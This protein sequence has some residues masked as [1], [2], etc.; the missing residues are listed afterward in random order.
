M[1][2][3]DPK[4]NYKYKEAKSWNRKFHRQGFRIQTNK[5]KQRNNNDMKKT[6]VGIYI[7]HPKILSFRTTSTE[8]N[9]KNQ[10]SLCKKR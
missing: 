8:I 6:V 3:Y 5:P 1:K 2:K 10:S 9:R 7:L 4:T